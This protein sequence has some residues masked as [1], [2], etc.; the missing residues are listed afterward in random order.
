M[1]MQQTVDKS[2]YKVVTIS[3]AARCWKRNYRTIKSACFSS[4][5]P[6][7]WR[8]SG[9]VYLITVESLKRR[10]GKPVEPLSE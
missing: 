7:V 2:L 5:K 8:Q 4:R 1:V 9:A 10:Y 6:L 3:E